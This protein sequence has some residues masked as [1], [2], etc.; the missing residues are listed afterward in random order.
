MSG[1]LH[2]FAVTDLLSPAP[3][4]S[5]AES[6]SSSSMRAMLTP[7][8][9]QVRTEAA[10]RTNTRRR[11]AWR[12]WVG[13]EDLH[14]P[15][16]GVVSLIA[17]VFRPD[18]FATLNWINLVGPLPFFFFPFPGALG[19]S[20]WYVVNV[21]NWRLSQ[22]PMADNANGTVCYTLGSLN[23]CSFGASWCENGG[24][25]KEIHINLSGQ[26]ASFCL[27]GG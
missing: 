18:C 14:P 19:R 16:V 24:R 8:G 22:R 5:C 1:R 15:V 3:L 2:L 20:G 9:R 10:Q 4:L 11:C 12:L 21:A 27:S 7:P 17:R 23:R 26:A 13:L 6:L 25:Q